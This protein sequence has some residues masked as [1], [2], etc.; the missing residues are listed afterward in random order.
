MSGSV[1]NFTAG[2][3]L[4]SCLI[5][6][7]V[8]STGV[9]AST[10]SVFSQLFSSSVTD[11]STVRSL[12]AEA[13]HV[14]ELQVYRATVLNSFVASLDAAVV[15]V[16]DASVSNDVLSGLRSQVGVEVA[17]QKS[18]IV[19]SVDGGVRFPGVMLTAVDM[20]A[21][22]AEHYAVVAGLVASYDSEVAAEAQRVA[23]AQAALEAEQDAQS[24]VYVPHSG[25]SQ[26]ARLQRIAAEVGMTVP[27]VIAEGCAG[28]ANVL[29]CFTLPDNFVN[30]TQFGLSRGDNDL[31]CTLQHENRHA[32]QYATGFLNY[33]PGETETDWRNRAEADARANGCG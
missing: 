24:A 7:A 10:G 22:V 2:I 6:G 14:A 12:T 11:S 20:D 25:E 27:V 9:Q 16:S 29:G 26:E 15:H 32:W 18:L 3:V 5:T 13:D 4:T 28:F 19:N 8:V 23:E 21:Y 33:L 31:R 1:R 30:I 17:F